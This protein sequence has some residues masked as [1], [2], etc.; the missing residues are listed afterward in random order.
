MDILTVER[1]LDYLETN[2]YLRNKRVNRK[3]LVGEIKSYFLNS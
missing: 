1:T 2:N 3:Q